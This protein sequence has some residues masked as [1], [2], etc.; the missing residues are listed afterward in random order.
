MI[1]RT[2]FFKAI[3]IFIAISHH[4][5]K[6]LHFAVSPKPH[7]QW[8]I[9]Q[10]RKTFAFDETAKYVIRDNDTILSEEFKQHIKYLVLEDTPTAPHSPRQKSHL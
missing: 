10:L 7:S 1:D 8:A 6:I 9:Q 4:R 2:L 5:R 3:Y